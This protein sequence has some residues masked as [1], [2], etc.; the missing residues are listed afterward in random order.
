MANQAATVH[1]TS[2]DDEED[3]HNNNS[4]KITW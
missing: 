2:Y 3:G 1:S 4:G